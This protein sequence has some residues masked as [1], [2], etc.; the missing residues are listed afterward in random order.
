MQPHNNLF[1]DL[2]PIFPKV[3]MKSISV[4]VCFVLVCSLWSRLTMLPTLCSHML[5]KS[6][7]LN[8]NITSEW[9]I[10]FLFLLG[11]INLQLYLSKKT[12][13][14]LIACECFCSKLSVHVVL[15]VLCFQCFPLCLLILRITVVEVLQLT[16]DLYWQT[17]VSHFIN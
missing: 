8:F 13:L 14:I 5:L 7:D 9:K 10:K 4:F 3:C 11:C 17:D 2:I 1:L 15:F 6:Q 12:L 16:G